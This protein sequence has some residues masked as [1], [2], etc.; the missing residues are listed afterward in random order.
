[1]DVNVNLKLI[2]SFEYDASRYS[3]R[4]IQTKMIIPICIAKLENIS[5]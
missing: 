2:L 5:H 3:P 4:R 1:M